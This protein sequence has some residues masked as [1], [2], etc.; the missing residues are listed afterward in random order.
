M[1]KF[2]L[3][4]MRFLGAHL[5]ER[6]RLALS[7]LVFAEGYEAR[8]RRAAEESATENCR[9]NRWRLRWVAYKT[10]ADERDGQY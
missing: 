6:N 2:K 4:A 10:T 5:S 9:S 3:F 8:V 1:V 7:S